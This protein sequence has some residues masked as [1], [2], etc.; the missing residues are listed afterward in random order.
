MLENPRWEK[1]CQAYA[2]DPTNAAAAYRN[3]GYKATTDASAAS[4]ATKLLKIAD[5]R[6]R[7]DEITAEARQQAERNSIAD[8]VEIRQRVT[9]IL[10]G[11]SKYKTTTADIL[12]AADLLTKIGGQQKPETVKVELS[13]EDKFARLD[14]LLHDNGDGGDD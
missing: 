4:C 13:L 6:A 2:I 14:A 3:A 1:F 8:I 12:K 9:D 5:I 10:R 11:Q 7:I